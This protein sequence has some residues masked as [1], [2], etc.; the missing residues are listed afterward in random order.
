MQYESLEVESNILATGKLRIKYDRDR[1]IGRF[2]ASTS[3]SF[4]AHPQVD[5]L[6]KLVKSLFS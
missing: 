2:E 3:D 4:V 1:R 6:K 5:E